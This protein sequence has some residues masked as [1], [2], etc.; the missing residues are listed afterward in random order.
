M[1]YTVDMGMFILSGDSKRS[2]LVGIAMDVLR[3]NLKPRVWAVTSVSNISTVTN[4]ATVYN[5]KGTC[6]G[7]VYIRHNH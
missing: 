7:S 6:I 1:T 4:N 2:C 5:S 3:Q